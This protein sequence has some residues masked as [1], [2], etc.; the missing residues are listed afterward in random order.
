MRLLNLIVA[1]ALVLAAGYVY[2]SKF[3]ATVEAERVAKLRIE[4]VRERDRIA[5]LRAETAKL[6]APARIEGLARRHLP[7]KPLDLNQIDT[8]DAV[9]FRPMEVTPRPADEPA[10]AK[11][12]S[13]TPDMATGS[14]GAP[15]PASRPASPPATSRPT[16]SA[17]ASRPASPPAASRPPSPPA[18]A[19]TVS[20]LIVRKPVA[21]PVASRPVS[22]PVT[23]RYAAPPDR[24]VAPLRPPADV[25]TNLPA[26]EDQR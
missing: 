11:T 7:L 8:V 4:I 14:I 16:S 6:E 3:A 5:A 22:P 12:D 18:A 19:R 20:P 23:P 15:T 21:A 9:P 2:K 13:A 17:V 25:W 26:T 1:A 10:I 24:A